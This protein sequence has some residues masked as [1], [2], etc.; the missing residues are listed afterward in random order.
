[1]N[2]GPLAELFTVMFGFLVSF[3]DIRT[4]LDQASN[5]HL[6]VSIVHTDK[7]ATLRVMYAKKYPWYVVEAT[8][9]IDSDVEGSP[10][11]CW[12]IQFGGLTGRQARIFVYQAKPD[13][14]VEEVDVDLLKG[15]NSLDSSIYEVI[16]HQSGKCPFCHEM[17]DDR[18]MVEHLIVE[19]CSNEILP[20]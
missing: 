2:S 13:L 14:P 7:T 5:E 19:H 3:K 15:V 10:N 12:V 17:G 11:D 8:R 9:A 16:D 4:H 6:K 1:V 20:W 18:K